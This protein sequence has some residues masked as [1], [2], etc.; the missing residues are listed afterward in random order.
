MDLIEIP[1]NE[2]NMRLIRTSTKPEEKYIELIIETLV[3]SISLEGTK[4]LETLPATAE[5]VF[6]IRKRGEA[7]KRSYIE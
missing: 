6:L 4:K 3:R 1:E 2:L 7:Y 5:V